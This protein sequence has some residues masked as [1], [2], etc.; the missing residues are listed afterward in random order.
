[1]GIWIDRWVDG[2]MDGRTDRHILPNIGCAS[3]SYP[4]GS[5][6]RVE[7]SCLTAREGYAAYN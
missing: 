1:M 5:H 2:W 4:E 6:F 7:F 3:R